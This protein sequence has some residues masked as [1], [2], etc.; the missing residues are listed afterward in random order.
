VYR[1]HARKAGA[2]A[3]LLAISL[4]AAGPATAQETET[5]G[6]TLAKTPST[7]GPCTGS[8]DCVVFQSTP[9]TGA[10][11]TPTGAGQVTEVTIKKDAGALNIQPVIV[12]LGSG[13][14]FNVRTIGETIALNPAAGTQAYPLAT[15]LD[16]ASGETV[17]YRYPDGPVPGNPQLFNHDASLP[18]GGAVTS[19]TGVNAPGTYPSSFTGANYD[20]LMAVKIARAAGAKYDLVAES[21]SA[22]YAVEIVPTQTLPL[23]VES[24]GVRSVS[25]FPVRPTVKNESDVPSL[26]TT[27]TISAAGWTNLLLPTSS[28]PG[29]GDPT[30]VA[31]CAVPALAPRGSHTTEGINLQL[32]ASAFGNGQEAWA[33]GLPRSVM[34]GIDI[35]CNSSRETSCTNNAATGVAAFDESAQSKILRAGAAEL[36]GNATPPSGGGFEGVEVSVLD[37]PD[38]LKGFKGEHVESEPAPQRAAAAAKE[39]RWLKNQK[40]KFS[41]SDPNGKT[42]DEPVW[43]AA[44]GTTK[45][46]YK[47]KKDLPPGKYVAYSRSTTD[48]DATEFYFDDKDG[49]REEFKVKK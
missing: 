8:S 33:E 49:N 3:L 26:A 37:V 16:I 30:F 21:A 39:C 11:N 23:I 22:R 20:L 2:G 46:S 10:T 5:F 43:L 32:P 27:A 1:R 42:C 47:L 36:A 41:T 48:A 29:S 40:A 44:K 34:I 28:C 31:T 35:E 17:G 25:A 14:S 7:S 24:G 12:V 4:L 6:S 19:V 15:P 9:S 18:N 45:W 38:G 13:S